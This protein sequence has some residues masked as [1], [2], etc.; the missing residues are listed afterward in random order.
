MAALQRQPD[1]DRDP[2]SRVQYR[3][4]VAW[5]QRIQREAPFLKSWLA[6]L[7]SHRLLDLGCGTGE[8]TRFLQDQGC[9]VV[10]LDA[11]PSMLSQAYTAHSA[12]GVWFVRGSIDALP[13]AAGAFGGAICLGNT[14]PHLAGGESLRRFFSELG[15]VLVPGGRLLVQMLNYC[16][17][18]EKGI[19]WL[20]LNFSADAETGG[21]LVFLRLMKLLPDGGVV[22]CPTTLRFDP[23]SPD[24][25]EVVRS[26][27]VI[28]HGWL[29]EDLRVAAE[30]A[31][32][33]IASVW[34]DMTEGEFRPL[35]SQ[36]LVFEAVATGG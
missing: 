14:L 17:V 31:G 26:R 3:K 27:R 15:R 16:R 13:L 23:A 34:G 32:M 28:L 30:A 29:L 24:P 18:F 11:S 25:V 6:R 4:L 9:S 7:P 21:E 12:P 2:Y 1:D 8:H 5:P 35:E 10:G 19:R 33:E 36:D 22:F 20:P